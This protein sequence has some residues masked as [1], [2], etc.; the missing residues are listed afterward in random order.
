M[1]A[2]ETGVVYVSVPLPRNSNQQDSFLLFDIIEENIETPL[3]RQT[4]TRYCVGIR[5]VLFA[6]PILKLG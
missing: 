1:P 3:A 6:V 2:Y 5:I 4:H